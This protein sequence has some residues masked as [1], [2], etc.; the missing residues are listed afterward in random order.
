MGWGCYE[1]T[2]GLPTFTRERF[3]FCQVRELKSSPLAAL[4]RANDSPQRCRVSC[5]TYASRLD[6]CWRRRGRCYTG[7]T[8]RA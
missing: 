8:I 1:Q 5:P 3:P 7:I 6:R 2:I 4:G